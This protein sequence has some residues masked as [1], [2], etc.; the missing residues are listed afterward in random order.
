MFVLFQI[1]LSLA[2]RELHIL[3]SEASQHMLLQPLVEIPE[4]CHGKCNCTSEIVSV[5]LVVE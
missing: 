1:R 5:D 3:I 2:G 4:S